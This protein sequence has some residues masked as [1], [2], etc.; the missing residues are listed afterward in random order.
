MGISSGS[1]PNTEFVCVS[2]FLCFAFISVLTLNVKLQRK[3]KT[4]L[5]NTTFV[6]TFTAQWHKLV[7]RGAVFVKYYLLLSFL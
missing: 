7:G 6:F 1:T 2:V 4:Q 5:L 3:I